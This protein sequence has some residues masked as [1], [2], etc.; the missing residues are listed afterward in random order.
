MLDYS[1]DTLA[2]AVESHGNV[3]VLGDLDFLPP[4][5]RELAFSEPSCSAETFARASYIAR[6]I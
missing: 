3:N 5:F 2:G 1:A 6:L 4:A